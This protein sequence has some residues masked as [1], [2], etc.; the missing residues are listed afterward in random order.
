MGAQSKRPDDNWRRDTVIVW[1]AFFSALS[2]TIMCASGCSQKIYERVIVQRDTTQI[3][4]VD[5]VRY[6]ERDSVFVREK[7]DTVYFVSP[8]SSPATTQS[9]SFII[10]IIRLYSALSTIKFPIR[11]LF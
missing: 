7:G 11:H 3:I 9:S 6:L 5:S 4:K 10:C 1:L 2:L 8:F